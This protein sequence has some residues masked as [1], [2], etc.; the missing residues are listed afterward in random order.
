MES[1][2]ERAHE[3]C[4][5]SM[6]QAEVDDRQFAIAPSTKRVIKQE[7]HQQIASSKGETGLR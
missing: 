6:R 1:E 7:R 3:S 5:K 2:R 4:E